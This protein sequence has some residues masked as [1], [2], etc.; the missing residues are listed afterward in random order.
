M[1]EL[2]CVVR[3]FDKAFFFGRF[4]MFNLVAHQAGIFGFQAPAEWLWR[5]L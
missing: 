4:F 3:F 1:V 5:G 2:P